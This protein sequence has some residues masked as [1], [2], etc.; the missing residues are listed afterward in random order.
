MLLS[1]LK[2]RTYLILFLCSLLFTLTAC[3][4]P[5]M[6]KLL[7]PLVR[8]EEVWEIGGGNENT[9]DGVHDTVL[10]NGTVFVYG[11]TLNDRLD[12]INS[13][14]KDNT[15]YQVILEEDETLEPSNLSYGKNDITI[16]I[17]GSGA[18]WTVTLPPD[19]KG[20]L[21]NIGKGVTLILDNGVTLQGKSNNQYLVVVK[22][23]GFL[24]MN[25]R[26]KITDN[27]CGG[28]YVGEGG[29]FT[30][31]GGTISDNISQDNGGGVFINFD[32]TFIMTSGTING[33]ISNNGSGV[34]VSGGWRD[35]YGMHS[36]GTFMVGGTAEV[37]GNV[38]NNVY[39]N[40]QTF[41]TISSNPPPSMGMKIHV[42]KDRS[43]SDVTIVESGASQEME[44]YFFSDDSTRK[45]IFLSRG[46]G[47][48]DLVKN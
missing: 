3:E 26:T 48:L 5:I 45:V 9:D 39:L 15:T 12:W 1:L 27:E 28:V 20:S 6:I 14:A 38:F 18:A 32:G 44:G 30:M 11:G 21:F 41:I 23:G 22:E 10:G 19:S 13:N 31:T 40:E 25:N 17:S 43:S 8:Q 4:N 47:V 16:N 24:V 34:Y 33:N 29:T 42:D 37:S 7:E 36:A 35:Q 2:R 46:T